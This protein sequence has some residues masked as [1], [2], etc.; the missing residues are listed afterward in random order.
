[1]AGQSFFKGAFTLLSAGV[2]V[3]IMGFAYQMVIVRLAG[4][5]AI[6]IFN[7][8]SPFYSM[9]MILTC[10]GI[11]AAIVRFIPEHRELDPTGDSRRS[12]AD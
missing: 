6:G 5:E 4:T 12:A 8:V 2:V 1:M 10:T 7:M 3:K 9:A 11:P